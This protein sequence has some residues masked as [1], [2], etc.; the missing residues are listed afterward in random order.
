MDGR[1]EHMEVAPRT[2]AVIAQRQTLPQGCCHAGPDCFS[3]SGVLKSRMGVQHLS[4]RHSL[5]T[6][7][8]SCNE[9]QRTVAVKEIDFMP[10]GPN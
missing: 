1:S 7:Q 2:W 6:W 9:G 4:E 8:L 10:Q 5:V 3:V